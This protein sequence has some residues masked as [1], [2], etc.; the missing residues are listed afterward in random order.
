MRN[1]IRL[2][3]LLVLSLGVFAFAPAALAGATTNKGSFNTLFFNSCNGELVDIVF[4]FHNVSHVRSDG[5]GGFH[6][7]SSSNVQLRG[8]GRTTGK[9]YTGKSSFTNSFQ[10]TS[11]AFTRTFNRKFVLN[12]QGKGD[13]FTSTSKQKFTRN[14]NGDITVNF[15]DFDSSCS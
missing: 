12:P 1:R 7:T 4:S 13:R 3:G 6:V 10:S 8:T 11:G 5:N 9:S 14:A 15:F 2:M